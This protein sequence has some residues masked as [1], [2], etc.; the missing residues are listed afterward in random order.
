LKRLVILLAPLAL[1]A[2]ALG[3]AAART[4]AP[5]RAEAVAAAPTRAV[6]HRTR[7]ARRPYAR[8]RVTAGQL[9][10]HA[11]HAAD[12]VPAPARCPRTLLTPTSGGTAFAINLVGETESPAGDPVGTG[13]A[14]V[15]VRRGQGQ[16]CFTLGAENIALPAA[17]AHIHRGGA[18]ENGGIVVQLRAPGASG[19]SSGCVAAARGLVARLL[20]SPDAYYVN[21]H[22]TEF[23]GG[24]IRAQLG[25]PRRDPGR[26]L[27]TSLTGAQECNNAGQCGVGDTDG[28]GS[29]VVRFR[30]DEAQVC[31]RITVQNIVLPSV[32]AHIHRGGQGSNGPI[33]VGF[34]APAAN[35]ASSGCVAADRAVIDAILASPTGYYVNVHTTDF[36]GG[37]I[38]GQ[39][40]AS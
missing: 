4:D 33:V 7:S 12:I 24:A 13:T 17:G 6:C 30:T 1:A 18:G 35:G 20:S 19:R 11:R 37:A 28:T 2:L 31:F 27:S 15:R 39:L 16:V 26:T 25:G 34:R 3:N 38:R 8:I 29:A 21:V 5:E 40:P 23:P 36:P 22:T 32:G 10:A 14:T 9:R